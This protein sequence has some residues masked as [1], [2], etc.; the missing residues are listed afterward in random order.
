MRVKI[1]MERSPNMARAV[2]VILI[3]AALLA[4]LSSIRAEKT[5]TVTGKLRA[6]KDNVMTIEKSG[7]L[8]ESTETIEINEATKTVGQ[9]RPGMR[10]KIKYRE[11]PPD[12]EGRRRKIAVEIEARPQ[13][14]DKKTREA[15]KQT[16][17]PN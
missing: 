13:Y 3:C 9:V 16:T 12:A 5:K 1:D 10:L 2:K 14:A 6:I 7:L 4:T 15:A 17:R 11:E 8:S